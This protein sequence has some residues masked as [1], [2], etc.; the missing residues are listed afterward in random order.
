MSELSPNHI[1]LDRCLAA[2]VSAN[3]WC[4][5][6][7]GG[8]DS[9]VLLHLLK[10]WST[11]Q[12]NPNLPELIAV[13]VNHGMQA[14]ADHF[15]RH[16]EVVCRAW[17]IPLSVHKVDVVNSGSG[18][19]AAA[20]TARYTAFEAELRPGDVLFMG[21]HLDDQVETFFL[22]LLRGS[23]LQGLSAMP[24]QRQLGRG[25]LI[26]PLLS[27]E[28]ELLRRYGVRQKL[29]FIDDP[30][31]AE[32]GA[33]RNFLRREVLPLL[34]TRWAGYRQTVA[35]ATHH[36]AVAGE[37]MEDAQP[38]PQTQHNLLGDPGIEMD[39]MTSQ[40]I[41]GAMNCLRRWLQSA[42]HTMPDRIALMEFVRQ[43]REA[44]PQANPRF[45]GSGYSLQ[46][47]REAVY[48]LPDSR[49]FAIPPAI[50]LGPGETC[51]V[52]GVG[53][54]SIVPAPANGFAIAPGERLNIRWRTGGERC[55][56]QG[57]RHGRSLKKLFQERQIPPWWRQ[58]LPLVY[59]GEELLAV[60]DVWLCES[61]RLGIP[62][63]ASKGLW[64][65]QWQR[66][67]SAFD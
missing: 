33:S 16:C 56:P 54:L 22:R 37:L 23:G 48:L 38:L 44:N 51:A 1:E 17:G 15:Q 65:L 31:N 14:A 7:S 20:R 36:L 53:A 39:W 27:M 35:R 24:V 55:R 63:K 40:P 66:N 42:G 47:Y 30:S 64:R 25:Q 26:R 5:A 43:L 12:A 18:A 34:A 45:D 8:L 57:R 60:A 2:Q 13:H 62:Q 59:L 32:S 50:T 52:A 21:H 61:S 9:T 11:A 49:E 41:E 6:F 67:S 3:R 19:E 46:R 10:A 4:V 58:R 28:R 29:A